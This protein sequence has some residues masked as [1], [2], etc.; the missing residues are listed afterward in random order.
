MKVDYWWIK[1]GFDVAKMWVDLNASEKL[2]PK[3]FP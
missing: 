3:T 1:M 2:V